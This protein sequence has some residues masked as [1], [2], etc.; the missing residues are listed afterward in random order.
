MGKG[1]S[2]AGKF[3]HS[4]RHT[5]EQRNV[6]GAFFEAAAQEENLST[7]M[8]SS[9]LA[10]LLNLKTSGPHIFDLD[11]RVTSVDKA[12]KYTDDEPG[13]KN[14]SKDTFTK[15][16][17][18]LIKQFKANF[19][20]IK[21]KYDATDDQLTDLSPSD[22]N[23]EEV[24]NRLSSI[25]V[26]LDTLTNKQG[27]I[28]ELLLTLTNIANDP[29]RNY[30]AFADEVADVVKKMKKDVTDGEKLIDNPTKSSPGYKQQ[31]D[32][33][34]A[35]LD[36]AKDS[37]QEVELKLGSTVKKGDEATDDLKK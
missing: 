6:L 22:A 9:D 3:E 35:D 24:K 21:E 20:S 33:T 34:Q 1:I 23:Y 4:R 2:A 31:M 14:L 16:N 36:K 13:H 19:D 25:G 7:L 18:E 28:N 17:D 10:N 12:E 5:N 37:L 29:T 11:G 15:W 26:T 30:E 27:Q 32:K 8:E